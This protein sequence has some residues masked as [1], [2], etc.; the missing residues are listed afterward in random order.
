MSLGNGHCNQSRESLEVA[1]FAV[2][3]QKG[4]REFKRTEVQKDDPHLSGS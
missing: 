4:K 3:E 1:S 2:Q